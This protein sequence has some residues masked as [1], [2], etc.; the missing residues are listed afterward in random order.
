M[1]IKCETKMKGKQ[2]LKLNYSVNVNHSL[3]MVTV[4]CI[5]IIKNLL[6]K[7]TCPPSQEVWLKVLPDQEPD[8]IQLTSAKNNLDFTLITCNSFRS[9]L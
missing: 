9:I 3:K 8:L 4:I 1:I 6:E 2:Q 5:A 7:L